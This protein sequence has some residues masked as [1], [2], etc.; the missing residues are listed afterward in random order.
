MAET[1]TKAYFH[2][3]AEEEFD[4]AVEFYESCSQGLGIEFSMEPTHKLK[5]STSPCPGYTKNLGA[6]HQILWLGTGSA[7]NVG[8]NWMEKA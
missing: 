4:K 7:A 5:S 3:F 1:M 2:E 6:K 8:Q